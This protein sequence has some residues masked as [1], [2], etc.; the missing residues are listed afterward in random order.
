MK[1]AG[2]RYGRIV[3]TDLAIED[4]GTVALMLSAEAMLASRNLDG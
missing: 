3:G 1:R 2:C 4:D